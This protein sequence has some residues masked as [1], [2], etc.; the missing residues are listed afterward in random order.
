LGA[1]ELVTVAAPGTAGVVAEATVAPLA[2]QVLVA[3]Y[4]SL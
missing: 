1:P 2:K 4:T 3:A